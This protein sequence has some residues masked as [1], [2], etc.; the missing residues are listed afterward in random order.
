MLTGALGIPRLTCVPGNR[1]VSVATV[2]TPISEVAFYNKRLI[3]FCY[4]VSIT[5]VKDA[6]KLSLNDAVLCSAER[7]PFLFFN[8][9]KTKLPY[10]V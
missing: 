10:N 2:T 8:L 5:T 4:K 1:Y 3:F 6:K 7:C 9:N